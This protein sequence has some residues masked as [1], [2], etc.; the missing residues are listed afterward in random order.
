MKSTKTDPATQSPCMRTKNQ[1]C[2][3]KYFVKKNTSSQ[4]FLHMGNT[5]SS[6]GFTLGSMIMGAVF[7]PVTGGASMVVAAG[8]SLGGMGA[9]CHH[10]SKKT[11]L[12]DHP[13]L[14]FMVGA[15][16][17]AMVPTGAG[18]AA[19]GG[20]VAVSVGVSVG[21]AIVGPTFTSRDGEKK[22]VP[23]ATPEGAMRELQKPKDNSVVQ[24]LKL[25]PQTAN[26]L[27]E[28]GPQRLSIVDMPPRISASSDTYVSIILHNAAYNKMIDDLHNQRQTYKSN[29]AYLAN[30]KSRTFV[31]FISM[32]TSAM[33]VSMTV[34]DIA[35][36]DE[37]LMYSSFTAPHSFD[38]DLKSSVKSM[39]AYYKQ[40]VLC[41]KEQLAL[42]PSLSAQTFMWGRKLRDLEKIEAEY[43][44]KRTLSI[45][46]NFYEACKQ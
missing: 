40:F 39:V 29:L 26:A 37:R 24:K 8:A 32:V 22:L 14:D 13:A 42:K 38:E 34:K 23:L 45:I 7:A 15:V 46:L 33:K 4:Y 43:K 19:M 5:E 36:T 11:P 3:C 28:N 18:V 9:T 6:M 17:G 41:A 10:A 20:E 16:S 35:T 44:D 31:S 30:L 1:P 25:D 21:G 12:S 2:V 27:W